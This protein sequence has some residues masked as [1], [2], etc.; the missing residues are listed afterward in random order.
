MANLKGVLKCTQ[1]QYNKLVAGET[2]TIGEKT[3][4]YDENILYVTEDN[5]QEQIDTLKTSKQDTLSETQL[6][7]VNSG[8]T[9][10]KVAQIETNTSDLE[11]KLNR[12]G[13]GE[14]NRVYVR[15][16]NSTDTSLPFTYSAEANSVPKRNASGQ[17][18]VANPIQDE[19]AVN[20]GYA[21][22][23][24]RYLSLSGEAGVLDDDQYE[25]VKQNDNLIIQRVGLD[26]RRCGY[27][28]NGTGDYIFFC[29]HY[30]KPNGSEEWVDY[31]ITIKQDKSWE[32]TIK[33]HLQVS[34][35]TYAPFVELTPASA[36]N[37]TLSDDDYTNLTEH[38]D[39]YII[40]NNEY[41]Y[42]ADDQNTTGI[43]S[44]THNGWNG[45]APQDKS[46]NITLSTKA[47][48]LAIGKTKYYR[49]YVQLTA[50]DKALYY[51]FSSTQSTAYTANTLPSMPDDIITAF[52][53]VANGYYS[54]VSGLVYRNAEG[55]LR[56]IMHGMYTTDG[57]NMTYLQ[58]T[59]DAATFV[60]DVVKTM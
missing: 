39:V 20:K 60:Q 34:E 53:V 10:E 54:S 24:Q 1:E 7:A 55:A 37:G 32:T 31:F 58:M 3:Y 18:Q 14:S 15:G 26:F 50:G 19:D 52:Q 13:T 11:G 21:D 33:N 12:L 45:D 5:T 9:S 35:Q 2:I 17:L 51:D 30:T 41:Y 47:W 56:V 28:S 44:Y 42:R 46:I 57:T 40:L 43:L 36:T 27:P 16:E 6:N 29:D 48:T 59:G 49:H 25:L 22:K 4:T 8:I 23:L 38:K